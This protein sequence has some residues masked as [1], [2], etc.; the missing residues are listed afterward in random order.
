VIDL[1]EAAL[2]ISYRADG[3]VLDDCE[4]MVDGKP[5]ARLPIS[6]VKVH[7][8]AHKPAIYEVTVVIYANRVTT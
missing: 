2:R 8:H 1:P 3:Q 5:V 4:V 7:A 6:E